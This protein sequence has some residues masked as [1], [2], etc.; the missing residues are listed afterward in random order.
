MQDT[1]ELYKKLLYSAHFVETRLAIGESMSADEAYDESVL[2]TLTTQLNL[3]AR[4]AVTVGSCVSGEIDL[5]MLEPAEPI[6]RN[7][8]LRPYVRLSNGIEHSEWLQKGVYYIDTRKVQ[9]GT[10]GLRILSIHGFDAMLRAEVD[11][12]GSDITWPAKDVDVV[13]CVATAIGVSVD[14][15]TFEFMTQAFQIPQPQQY[16]CREVLGYVAAMYAGCF[17]MSDL[18]R[19]LLVPL[20]S[21]PDALGVL[22]DEYGNHIA[23]GGDTFVV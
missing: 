3:F 16:S 1:S 12:A 11:F 13:R 8:Q 2:I 14:P 18:G 7:A 23:I 17:I 21:L 9:S 5:K 4:D 6:P 22:S 20:W 10:S 15:R 19:L